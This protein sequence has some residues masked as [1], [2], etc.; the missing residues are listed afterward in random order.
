MEHFSDGGELKILEPGLPFSSISCLFDT[1]RGAYQTR[2]GVERREGHGPR[3]AQG[4]A[5]SP[6]PK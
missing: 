2:G 3:D 5:G 4:L 6:L 1:C